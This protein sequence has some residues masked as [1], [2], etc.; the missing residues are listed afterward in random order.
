MGIEEY[1][2]PEVW[3]AR[4]LTIKEKKNKG[5]LHFKKGDPIAILKSKGRDFYGECG[6]KEG[7]FPKY[8]VRKAPEIP[9]DPKYITS[10][11]I[12]KSK[13]SKLASKFG[14]G[15]AKD[16]ST[17]GAPKLPNKPPAP[18]P[19]VWKKEVSVFGNTLAQ[20]I[21][22]QK[23][24]YPNLRVPLFVRRASTHILL[25]GL[26]EEGPFRLPGSSTSMKQM[27]EDMNGGKDVLF[28][29]KGEDV[30]NACD[31]LKRFCKELAEP[32][33]PVDCEENF[34]ACIVSDP[35]LMIGLI[36]E[37][38]ATL[39]PPNYATLQE[40]MTILYLVT[41]NGNINKMAP[42][43]IALMWTGNLFRG[44]EIISINQAVAEM[45]SLNKQGN[46]Q[47]IV[48][49]MIENYKDLFGEQE[50]LI[51]QPQQKWVSF[52]GKL[53]GHKRGITSI[54]KSE[55]QSMIWSGELF[56]YI[57]T[58]NASSGT[59]VKQFRVVEDAINGIVVIDDLF[60]VGT[61][62]G[63]FVYNSEGEL[64]R[65]IADLE[66]N[67]FSYSG[68]GSLWIG[69]VGKVI[70]L[71]T[72]TMEIMSETNL[73]GFSI[74]AMVSVDELLWTAG[75]DNI[76]RV[77]NTETKEIVQE[78]SVHQSSVNCVLSVLDQVWT[79]DDHNIFIWD[80]SFQQIAKISRTEKLT[81]LSLVG[82]YVWA[83]SESCV[84]IFDYSSGDCVGDFRHYHTNSITCATSFWNEDRGCWQAWTGSN[85]KSI[86]IWN[87][88][89]VDPTSLDQSSDPT[90]RTDI[91]DDPPTE[92]FSDSVED[93]KTDTMSMDP[94]VD[95][96]LASDNR[97]CDPS[98]VG[99]KDKKERRSFKRKNRIIKE[100]KI[101]E[102][103]TGEP[104]HASKTPPVLMW[105]NVEVLKW[106][107]ANGEKWK[108]SE[109]DIKLV[110]DSFKKHR[111]NGKLLLKLTV[112]SMKDDLGIDSTRIRQNLY[113]AITRL[114]QTKIS[115]S[116]SSSSAT[117][118]NS[119][120]RSH[121]STSSSSTSSTR[122]KDG[123]KR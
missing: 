116:S 93:T 41:I 70:H 14:K 55:D 75:S 96:D 17:P 20:L 74:I 89:D 92:P 108:F 110:K 59:F 37:A 25:Y 102:D 99:D 53:V 104:T 115:S 39:P 88:K 71:N 47:A 105:T 95:E 29:T 68:G 18:E 64:Q 11:T 114:K 49:K 13:K 120:E 69:G 19:V 35:Q 82:P 107:E 32:V 79:S 58:W 28:G 94:T 33:V 22:N 30:Y 51:D 5:D 52:S 103:E 76:I 86:C 15:K 57:R 3:M 24:K 34:L 111:V 109:K 112:E 77:W 6:G 56:G 23:E 67:G 27:K 31:L 21:E 16:T 7:W 12:K 119:R 9:L 85:D 50:F 73:G 1:T 61:S 54:C 101:N 100:D 113:K 8:Y 72:E 90:R 42:M 123:K 10:G 83:F 84:F 118:S 97:S 122:S 65:S 60:W 78:L 63:L 36:K 4:T 62:V 81:G 98:L 121:R 38:L 87:I 26:A 43:A 66:V 2:F 106:V 91:T 40:I 48:I 45:E 44:S 117:S 46:L 80:S